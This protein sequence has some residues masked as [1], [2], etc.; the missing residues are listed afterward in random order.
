MR[1]RPKL[2]IVSHIFCRRGCETC[3]GFR[4]SPEPTPNPGVKKESSSIFVHIQK[5][6]PEQ[7]YET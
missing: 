6:I 1:R 2:D 4:V 7:I 3:S 5:A